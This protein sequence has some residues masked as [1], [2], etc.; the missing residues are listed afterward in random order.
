M[1]R[2]IKHWAQFDGPITTLCFRTPWSKCVPLCMCVCINP[3]M[4]ASLL[5]RVTTVLP[6]VPFSLNEKKAVAAE[7]L[8]TLA[9]EMVASLSPSAVESM[10]LRAVSGYI[11]TEGARSLYRAVSSQLM[12]CI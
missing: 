10:V 11:P 3:A 5:S 6:F 4:Q 9:G 1:V 7:A 12:D 2:Y 8:Y